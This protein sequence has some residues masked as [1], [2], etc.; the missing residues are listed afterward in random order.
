MH[1]V[2]INASP[3]VEAKSNTA[4]IVR[5][6]VRGFEEGG[7]TTEVWHLSDRKQWAGAKEAYEKNKNI[8]FAIP[9]YVENV[10]GIMLEFL[11]TLQPKKEAGTK[12][13]FILQG[14]FAEAS[15]LRCGEAYLE[16][17]PSYF[18]C[19]YNGTLIKGDNFGPAWMPETVAEKMVV[20]YETMGKSFAQKGF[21]DKEEVNQFAGPEYFSEKTI[22]QHKRIGKWMQKAMF[23]HIAKKNGCKR[24][25]D[26]RPYE[27]K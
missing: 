22:R 10:P 21:F 16:L 1:L 7:N 20:R 18:N 2:I 11:E 25:L 8:L 27:V 17:L 9:L 6:F 24:P 26:D 13:S 3:R 5:S 12:M 14:G 15:Q 19:E 23:R 4:R